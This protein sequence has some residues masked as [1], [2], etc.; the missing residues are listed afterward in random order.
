V[1][2]KL[3]LAFIV[4][5]AV[6]IALT[7]SLVSQG[8]STELNPIIRW[9]MGCSLPLVLV[10]KT[11]VPALL[12]VIILILSKQTILPITA[13]GGRPI[14]WTLILAMLVAGQAG[15]CLFDTAGL[16]WK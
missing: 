10:Y 16:I 8:L 4:L 11:A 15:I 12:V 3:A 5:S 14:R 2:V 1:K 9:M 6:D 7:I 13:R